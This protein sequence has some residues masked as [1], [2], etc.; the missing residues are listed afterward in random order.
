MKKQ[1]IP[2]S[3]E[4]TASVLTHTTSIPQYDHILG[5]LPQWQKDI[6]DQRLKDLENESNL[7]PIDE[8]LD[9]LD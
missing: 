1:T 2:N 8:L 7:K 9:L 6:L 3:E 4:N 5:E